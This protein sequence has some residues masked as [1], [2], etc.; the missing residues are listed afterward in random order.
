MVVHRRPF[1]AS[2]CPRRQPGRLYV[3]GKTGL[4][5]GS[6]PKDK[7]ET[8]GGG[9]PIVLETT[10]SITK[11]DPR[12]TH[13]G[14]QKPYKMHKVNLKAGKTYVID[15]F[16]SDQLDPYLILRDPADKTVAEDDDSAGDLNARIT[17][18]PTQDGEFRLI[19]TSYAGFGNYTLIVREKK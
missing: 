18:T 15:L 13:D 16:S 9:N 8:D 10:G 1:R 3:D 2:F 5:G 14:V 6:D 12:M 7:E 4:G 11:T 19:A 17:Y